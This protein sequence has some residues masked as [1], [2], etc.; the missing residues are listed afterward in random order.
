MDV[1]SVRQYLDDPAAAAA[2]LLGLGLRDVKRAHACLL[3]IAAT[4]L[5]F[6]LLAVVCA[7]LEEHLAGCAD[8][9]MALNNLGRFVAAGRNPLAMGTLFERDPT[10]MPDLLQMF[11]TSQHFSD[12]LVTDPESFDLLRLTEGQ[13]VAR[14]D[15]VGDLVAEVEA[16]DHE[17][18]VQAALRR[19]KH[20]ETLRIAY[21]D[22]IRGQPL[23]KVTAQISLLADAIL[24]AGLRAAWRK[25]RQRRG[26]PIAPD[27]KPARFVVLGLGKLGGLELNYSS[28][29]DLIFL[30]DGDGVT[31]GQRQITNAEFFNQ[32]GRELVHLLTEPTGLG[33]AYRVD[34][35]LRPE[36]QR[37]PMVQS[38]AGA[39][40]YYDVRGRTW[41]RQAYLKARPVAGDLEL[42]EQFL[43]AL[44]PWVYRRYLSRADISEIKALKR[45]IE[46]QTHDVGADQRDVKTGH[47][48]IRDVEFV[49]QF[50]QLLN[51]AD[52]PKLRTGNTLDAIAQLERVGCLSNQEYMLLVENYSFLRKI[53]HRL[54]IMFDLQ[55]HMLPSD[56]DELGKLALRMDY[57]PTP[58]RTALE[59]F[60]AD[61][62]TKT[63]LNRR[64]LDHLL[65][66]AFRDETAAQAEVDLVLDPDPPESQIAE[67]LGKYPFR[68]VTQAYRNLMALAEE[69]IR[70]LSTRRCRHFLAAIAPPLLAAVA[71]TPDPD[72]TLVNLDQVSSSLGGKGVL[73]ELFSFNPP[74][75]RLYVDLCAYSP[76]LSG[77]LTSNPGMIDGLMD[78]LVLDKLPTR[79]LLQRTVRHLTR[80]AEDLDPILHS[81]KNDQQLR[82]GVRDLL[83]KEDVGAITGVLS[84]VAETCLVQIAEREY[85]RLVTRFGRPQIG[86]GRR[87]GKACE[88]VILAMGKFGGREMNYHSDLDLVFLYEADG[89]TVPGAG[90]PADGSTT[91]QHFFSELGRRIVSTTSRLSA[92]GRLFEVD[93]RLRPTGK[94]G[95]L[96]TSLAEFA[97]YFAE[98]QGQ[99]WERQALCKARVVYGSARAAKATMSAVAKA[100]FAHRWRR[101]DADEVRA[102]RQRLQKTADTGDLK[103]GPG[104][105]VDIEFLVQM[106]QLKHGRHQPGIHESNT[107]QALD[108]LHAE[109]FLSAEDRAF[110]RDS[111]RLLRTIEGGLR[112]MNSTARDKLP[113]GPTELNKLARLLRYGGSDAL[114]ADFEKSTR[115]I[116]RRFDQIFDA[117]GTKR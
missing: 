117:A 11:A 15:L 100:A 80:G 50:L 33:Y 77:I 43:A 105:I 108:A 99:L 20:R 111:Y 28:D 73:W 45:R 26:T 91:N 18:T 10:A 7:Q 114:L 12:L 69:R 60:E 96:A 76:Y 116:R 51:G 13:P 37:G 55:T 34:L 44:A 106:L 90:R 71:A 58:Q 19:F 89:N 24:E 61:Y 16:L 97:R 30:Y 5:T 52:L 40:E 3:Q 113:G 2:W 62:R 1:T 87:A 14:A 101:R 39:S 65:H 81:Y 79:E 25:L 8:P 54:Q 86:E 94:S 57:V 66:D 53:E 17:T 41:E 36:G 22:I 70:F 78:S 75:L 47:G 88:M 103:R 92:Y 98:G 29:I 63:A 84:D 35:R 104:G 68:D 67:V 82:V 107:L 109:G 72:A 46:Q 74:S 42:G 83:G 31:D 9:D 32:L 64:I 49:I 110:F 115:Q 48:G 85:A 23:R 27:G 59:V 4:G 93:A 112:L 95:P 6:D 21:G 38:V 56:R 102:M